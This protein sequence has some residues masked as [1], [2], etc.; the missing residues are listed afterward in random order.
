MELRCDGGRGFIYLDI[1]DKAESQ[2]MK[3]ILS[4]GD[5]KKVFTLIARLMSDDI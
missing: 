5:G 1:V 3:F 4:M 2:S